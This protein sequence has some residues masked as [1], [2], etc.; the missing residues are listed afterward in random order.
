MQYNIYQSTFSTSLFPRSTRKVEYLFYNLLI[1]LDA[2]ILLIY[3]R[4]C[5]DLL[6][7]M[8]DML[9]SSNAKICVTTLGER[10][11]MIVL[12]PGTNILVNKNEYT[13]NGISTIREHI[14]KLPLTIT[15]QTVTS[16]LQSEYTVLTCSAYPLKSEDIV[17]PTG[18]G[19][20][21]IGGF[22]AGLVSNYEI[23]DCV[24]LATLVAS[25]KLK[26]IGARTCLPTISQLQDQL[27]QRK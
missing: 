22:I 14:S 25:E 2:L 8:I 1:S 20:A 21:F 4:K 6:I 18:A 16:Q 24:R 5:D 17:D 26:C 27:Q 10:G 11:C 23:V 3:Y 9:E 19:D 7:C 12:R 13:F 15:T